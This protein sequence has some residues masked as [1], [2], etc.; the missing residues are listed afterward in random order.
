MFTSR[1]VML[2]LMTGFIVPAASLSHP[3]G[4]YNTSLAADQRELLLR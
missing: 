1:L 2:L 4:R 3:E